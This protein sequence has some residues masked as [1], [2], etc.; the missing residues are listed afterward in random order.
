MI[1]ASKGYSSEIERLIGMGADVDALTTEGAT[2]LIFAVEN[3]RLGVVNTLLKHNPDLEL[4]TAS[5]ETPLL[6]AVKARRFEIAETLIR[7]GANFE[8][9]DRYGATCLHYAA[10]KGYLEMLD[11]LLYYD[12]Y[13]DAR[14]KDGT[15]PL[16]A[17]IYAG[18]A[19]EADLLIQNNANTELSDDAGFTPFLLAA[20]Y[21]DTL[22]MNILIKG[23]ADIYTTTNNGNNALTLSIITGDKT[24]TNYLLK[25]GNKWTEKGNNSLDPYKVASKYSRQDAIDILQKN[26]IKGI[27]NYEIDQMGFSISSRFNFNDF[28]TGFSLCFKEP[29]LN[30]GFIS[31][32][33]MKLWNT[34][35]FLKETE[36]L[37]YQYHHKAYLAY[38]GIFK[39]FSI[40][41]VPGRWNTSFSASL[42]AGYSFA[43]TLKGT[44]ITPEDKFKLIP[45]AS[46]KFTKM[47]YTFYSGIEYIKTPFY[48][49]GPIWVRIG[50]TFN[51]FFDDIRI[52]A[53]QIKWY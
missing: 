14:S 10:I 22:I 45:S 5:G 9:S 17:A 44:S 21:G 28:Y 2:A 32:L 49:N 26:N 15:T 36:Q 27:V 31:G 6:L 40:T 23:G 48:N 24:T 42:M 34:R 50:F 41:D 53:K 1:A 38:A 8:F 33:D 3:N 37:F 52:R 46:F 29:Y 4:A 47:N 18:N 43:N 39:D 11:L 20:F 12:A 7:A 35:V 25:R 13:T 19:A 30:L 16:L 51:Y